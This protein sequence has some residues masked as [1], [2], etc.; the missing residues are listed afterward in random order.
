MRIDQKLQQAAAAALQELYGA[1]IEPATLQ[2]QPTRKEFEGDLTLVVFPMTRHSR[3]KPEETAQE[4]GQH[5][6]EKLEEVTAFQVVKGFLN[7]SLSSSHWSGYLQELAGQENLNEPAPEQQTVMVEYSS[8]NT[9]KPLHLGHIRNNLLG[10]SICNVLKA[11][12]HRVLM[13]NLINDRGIHICKS[14]L[15]WQKWGDG[16][17]PESSGMK[18]DHLVGKYYVLFDQKLKLEIESMIHQGTDPK[19]AAKTA[20]LMQEARQMLTAW[21]KDDPQ[22]RQLWEMMN[23]WVYEGFEQTYKELGVTF[24]KFYYESETYLL[25]KEV[26]Q[27]GLEKGV[28]YRK[29]DGSVWVDLTDEGL[30]EKLLLRADGT[31][32]YMTQD[33]GT[34][35]MKHREADLDLNVYV[36]GNEQDYHFKVLALILKKLGNPDWNKVYHL[37][38]GMVDL[39]HGKMK[40]RE[41]TVVDADDL[42]HEMY[43]VASRTT[44]ESGRLEG[45]SP[46]E[47]EALNRQIGL[48]ALKFYILKTDP[49]KRMVFNPEESIDFQGHTGPFV[50]YAHA[51]IC[52]ILRKAK[53]AGIEPQAAT[54]EPLP[55]ERELLVQMAQW[56]DTLQ[57]SADNMDPSS[58]ANWSFD[59]AKT[60]NRFYHEVPIMQEEDAQV[61]AWRL[62]LVQQLARM[63]R[64]SMSLLGVELPEQM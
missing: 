51:R 62:L 1:T 17:T 26:V 37:S 25:G 54:V 64:N 38:Y 44:A 47:V 32:V 41:G 40:S 16:E 48:A 43:E 57:V 4:L 35:L 7:L 52:S 15:A 61:K 24:D 2:V 19:E 46:E 5:L 33:I 53:D 10:Y 27:E 14:M 59:L 34:A 31:S 18:G 49:K 28:F 55:A 29:D 30:D 3:K 13:V 20:P 50:Q 45:R 9:N 60:F 6:Q 42:M 58:V 36:V 12:G 63:L 22:V 11:R 21:E 8:P 23:G 39:P 56:Q